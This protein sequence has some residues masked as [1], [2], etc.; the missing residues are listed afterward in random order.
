MLAFN[1]GEPQFQNG[2]RPSEGRE[3]DFLWGRIFL[4]LS[5]SSTA[6]A[7]SLTPVEASGRVPGQLGTSCSLSKAASQAEEQG[8]LNQLS[9]AL[10]MAGVFSRQAGLRWCDAPSPLPRSLQHPSLSSRHRT[11]ARLE[12]LSTETPHSAGKESWD[13][14]H[15]SHY[16]WLPPEVQCY[17]DKINLSKFLMIWH[18]TRSRAINTDLPQTPSS[19]STC[20]RLC[21]KTP[22]LD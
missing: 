19:C 14:H 3:K 6:S 17:T 1:P 16:P 12:Q 13:Q 18:S 21:H 11:L 7:E 22:C 20:K 10:V 15:V 9:F 2:T 5:V 4:Q 8:A